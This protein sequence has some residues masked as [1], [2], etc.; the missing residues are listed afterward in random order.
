MYMS[1]DIY[2]YKRQCDILNQI[3]Y[4]IKEKG[5]HKSSRK[6][7]WWILRN[8]TRL[9]SAYN[10]SGNNIGEEIWL[11]TSKTYIKHKNGKRHTNM[12]INMV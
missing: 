9:T 3:S 1:C 5:P 10:I 8:V 11:Y 7:E 6:I 12:D 2:L 4:E